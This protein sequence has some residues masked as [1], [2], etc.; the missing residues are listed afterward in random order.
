MQMR[1]DSSSEIR[2]PAMVG[3]VAP[4]VAGGGGGVH[5]WCLYQG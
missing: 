3:T 4:C 2:Q 5:W 1:G